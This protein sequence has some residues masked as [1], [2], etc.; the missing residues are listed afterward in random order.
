LTPYPFEERARTRSAVLRINDLAGTAK[1]AAERGLILPEAT[2]QGIIK[3]TGVS[4]LSRSVDA[5]TALSGELQKRHLDQLK[6]LARD[7]FNAFCEYVNPEEP[8]ASAWHQWLTDKLQAIEY[9]PALNRFILNCPPGHAKP[10]HVDTPVLM[11]DGAW[12]RLGDVIVG[13]KVISDIG[14]PRRVEVVHRQG[15]LPL[16]KIT[17]RAGRTILSAPDHSFRVRHVGYLGEHRSWT[18]ACDLRPGDKLH[19]VGGR[20]TRS[21]RPDASGQPAEMFKLA[22]LYAALGG[23]T[24]G[25]ASKTGGS[26]RNFQMWFTYANHLDEV[27]ALCDALGIAY[28]V[29]PVR[30][31]GGWMMRLRS[32]NAEPFRE[33]LGLDVKAVDR[34]VPAWVFQG[35]DDLIALY[36]STYFSVRG[37]RPNRYRI[38]TL[39]AHIKSPGYALDL[40][41]LLARFDVDADVRQK[42]DALR[43]M[44]RVRAGAIETL[45]AAGIRFPG[46][47]EPHFVA[48]RMLGRTPVCDEVKS[49]EPAGEGECRCLTVAHD[50]TFV[51]DGV[52]VHNSTYASRL[53]V[54]WRLGRN[55][56][57]KI[58]GGGHTQR[59]VEN[60]F[61]KKIRN[62]IRAPA[63][64]QVFPGVVI[65]HATS[66]ADQWAIA[67]YNGEYAAKGAGQAVHGF[68]AN[69][70]VVDDPYSKIEVAESPTEREKIETWFTGD[71]GSRMLPFGKMFL[72]QTRFHEND[73]TGY[74]EA[75]NPSLPEHDRWLIVTAPALCIDPDT[76]VLGRKLGEVLWSYYDLSYFVT[77][78][79]EW[80]FQR[81]AL[82]YQ[83]IADAASEESIAGQFKYYRQQPHQTDEAIKQAKADGQ[84]DEL[85]RGKPGRPALVAVGL[86]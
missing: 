28:K 4:D 60:Q 86:R 52:V 85:G 23:Y 76:D 80:K 35:S 7:E 58:I 67:G 21:P 8:P 20:H 62:L 55:P 51:A 45:L 18:Q 84:V 6:P 38:A 74:L 47:G 12:K 31:N 66:A 53:F 14:E 26:C 32:K 57:L 73:L 30:A 59:F 75:M 5:L 68:R 33:A 41:R 54:A 25:K 65:D 56:N 71:L 43:T 16:L 19:I 48:K 37:E 3:L 77:K 69:F 10:L 46:S 78:K 61:S 70:I 72:V 29:H 50:H 82:V 42:P 49:I 1:E 9:D 2:R 79:T 44:L 11:A 64:K 83:Q 81:F 17:T 34:R 63:F 27:R 39:V 15:V 24:K 13:D 36:L 22:A 40:Q